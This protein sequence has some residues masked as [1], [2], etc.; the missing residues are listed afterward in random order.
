MMFNQQFHKKESDVSC[1]LF[2]YGIPCVYVN[3]SGEVIG[4][5]GELATVWEDQ[6]ATREDY[7]S[8]EVVVTSQAMLMDDQVDS[9]PGQ[10]LKNENFLQKS[11]QL[12]AEDM[13]L[14]KDMDIQGDTRPVKVIRPVRV[15]LV[16]IWY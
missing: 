15:P 5:D 6:Q 14:E 11:L 16:T 9:P 2:S 3:P 12:I 10:L 1:H 7:P 13:L 4:K 8:D